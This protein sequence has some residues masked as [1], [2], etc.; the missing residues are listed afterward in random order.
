MVF[1]VGASKQL[2]SSPLEASAVTRT[3]VPQFHILNRRP[4]NHRSSLYLRSL[5]NNTSPGTSTTSSQ[6]SIK[7]C[8]VIEKTIEKGEGMT[9][10]VIPNL[11]HRQ[12]CFPSNGRSHTRATL[13]ICVQGFPGSGGPRIRGGSDSGQRTIYSPRPGS[14]PQDRK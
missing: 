2:G 8:F 11:Q 6:T 14:C 4:A 13:P 10:R 9:M 1:S 7:V 3:G 5:L 12:F